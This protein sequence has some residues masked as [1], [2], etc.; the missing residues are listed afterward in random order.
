VVAPFF[1]LTWAESRTTRETS[2]RPASSS[3]CRTASWRR[4]QTP[5]LDQIRNLRCAVDFDVPK[6]G[7]KARQAQPLTNT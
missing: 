1:A 2:I 6:H 5:A 3:R 7:G 4:H